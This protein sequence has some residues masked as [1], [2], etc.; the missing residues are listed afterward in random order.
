[1]SLKD[2]FK[3]TKIV[4]SSSLND[5]GAEVESDKYIEVHRKL[6]HEFIPP[7]NFATASNFA[8]Y[9]SAERYYLDSLESIYSRYPYDGSRYEQLAWEFSAS[10]L[11]EWIYRNRYPYSKGMKRSYYSLITMMLLGTL[12]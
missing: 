3:T 6:R 10:H 9:G 2:K 11:D 12:H 4:H 8:H 1:M 5:L 7:A